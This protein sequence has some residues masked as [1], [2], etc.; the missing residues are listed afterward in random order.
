MYLSNHAASH[1]RRPESSTRESCY[2][3][4]AAVS[5]F[6]APFNV[7]CWYCHLAHACILHFHS[8]K[9]QIQVD[10][11]V[12]TD[13]ICCKECGWS[14]VWEWDKGYTWSCSTGEWWNLTIKKGIQHN[15]DQW[16]LWYWT[17]D[18]KIQHNLDQWEMSNGE[19]EKEIEPTVAHWYL[20]NG[21]VEKGIQLNTT[22]MWT[23]IWTA[24][25]GIWPSSYQWEL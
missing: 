17:V 22:S 3:I 24:E 23:V 7:V 12:E 11:K 19:V 10:A 15:L 1:F 4:Q 13:V 6:L 9:N 18:K 2:I 21:T 14:Q 16:E 5:W 20:Q 25:K 8:W